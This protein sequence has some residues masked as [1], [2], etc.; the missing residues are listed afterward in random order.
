MSK[1]SVKLPTVH[2]QWQTDWL[3]DYTTPGGVDEHGWQYATDFPAT[4]KGKPGFTDLVRRR[5]WARK[6]LIKTSGPWK[7]VGS[8]RLIDV[9]MQTR[10]GTDIVDLW[11]VASNGDALYRQDVR[12]SCPEGASW[13]HVSS[14]AQFQSISVGAAGKVWALAKDGSAFI[15]LGVSEQVPQGQ[16]WLQVQPPQNGPDSG[17]RYIS[18]GGLNGTLVWAIDGAQRLYLRQEVTHVFPEGTSWLF[19]TGDVRAISA[20]STH[21]ELWAVLESATPANLVDGLV[22]ALVGSTGASG[23]AATGR[24]DGVRGVLARR[25]GVTPSNPTGTGWDIAI[26]GGWKDVSI[27][28]KLRVM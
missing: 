1:D 17:L 6:C 9:S 14:D 12:L 13:I 3:I 2:W 19:V 15:R 10:P 4:Y 22:T 27:R 11:A 26:G 23:G 5:R 21:G 20:G 28:G 18:V 24:T 25:S 16:H 8:T 7:S